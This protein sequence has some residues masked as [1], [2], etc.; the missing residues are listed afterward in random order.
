MPQTTFTSSDQRTI[1]LEY[2]T[3]G[4]PEHPTLL[5]I[6]GY[7]AQMVQW[8]EDFCR[9]FVEH[10]FHVV[11]FDNRD[12]GLSTRLDGVAVDVD[13]VITAALL[14]E[15]VPPVPYTLS[16]MANDARCL[17]DHLGID[18]AHVLGA[19]MGG[20]IAQTMA[21]DHP[22]RVRSLISVMSQPGDPAVG[23]PEPEAA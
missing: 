21:I 22:S 4:D 7:T 18:A 1:T 3:F 15:P 10:D 23:Q 5:L 14:E 16:D 20:M 2:D 17:L 8:E 12:C 19:S 9:L 13:K 11:R 6:M